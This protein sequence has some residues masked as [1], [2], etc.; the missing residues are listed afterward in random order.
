MQHDDPSVPTV[1]QRAQ[2]VFVLSRTQQRRMGGFLC[3]STRR[4]SRQP[5][6]PGQKAMKLFFDET[7]LAPQP[8]QYMIN[9]RIVDPFE[10][11]NRATTL[12]EAL[13]KLGLVRTNPADFGVEPILQVHAE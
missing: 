6:D 3:R 4:N 10:N 13:A 11:P 2:S 12:I 9:G 8:K 1:V 5:R 7:Q